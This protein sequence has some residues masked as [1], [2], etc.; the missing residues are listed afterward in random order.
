MTTAKLRNNSCELCV[1]SLG[2]INI[3]GNSI[4][5]FLKLF[6]G[7][8]GHSNALFADGIHSFGDV[9]GSCVMVFSLKVAKKKTDEKYPFGYGK[10]EFIAAIAIYISLFI[11]GVYIFEKAVEHL[12]HRVAI[13]PDMV[14]VIGAGISL[15]ANELMYRQSICCGN[16]L[17]SPS[18]VANAHEKRADMWASGIVLIGIVGAKMGF[19]FLDPIAAIIVAFLIF[20]LCAESTARSIRGLVDHSLDKDNRELIW[21]ELVKHDVVIRNLRSREVGQKVEIEVDLYVDNSRLMKDLEELRVQIKDDILKAVGR[22]GD[23]TIYFYPK[24]KLDR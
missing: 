21:N 7:I 19:F 15:I 16:Q 18:M 6:L 3:G 23:V 2:W 11:I 1:K 5:A 20:R 22:P 17:N 14:T 8:V 12:I 13:R 9:L 4:I 10:V 24:S